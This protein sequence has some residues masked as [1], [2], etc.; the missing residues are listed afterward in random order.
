MELKPDY[1]LHRERREAILKEHP[2]IRSL[3]G[4]DPR[5]AI[6]AFAIVG[7]ML[8][9]A[10]LCRDSYLLA[11]LFGF[12]PGPYLD[13][14]VLVLI[15]EATHFLVF[16]KPAANRLLSIFT[17]TVMCAPLSEV[18]GGERGVVVRWRGS[19]FSHAHACARARV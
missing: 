12:G 14:G 3:Y 16:K 4:N 10:W 2:E 18:S 1:V 7:A 19:V 13:A 15:H 17:N 9:L 5:M 11:I 6:Y 8:S